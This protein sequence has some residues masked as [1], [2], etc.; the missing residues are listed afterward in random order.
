MCAKVISPS[1]QILPIN[2]IKQISTG[3]E[4][5]AMLLP[6]ILLLPLSAPICCCTSITEINHFILT[7]SLWSKVF[8][9]YKYAL[10]LCF[11]WLHMVLHTF[12]KQT[13]RPLW[14][15][16]IRKWTLRSWISARAPGWG[17][18][19]WKTRLSPQTAY[20]EDSQWLQNILKQGLRSICELLKA[21]L[22]YWITYIQKLW[23]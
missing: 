9:Y 16:W 3:T 15:A 11:T 17:S 20:T 22:Q 12:L 6:T 18:F 13:T 7:G 1:F 10:T 21:Q 4:K 14:L 23:Q 8:Q 5:Q 2:Q 19:S